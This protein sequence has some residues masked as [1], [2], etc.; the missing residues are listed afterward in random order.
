MSFLKRQPSKLIR[1]ALSLQAYKIVMKQK[2][3]IKQK[4]QKNSSHRE[5]LIYPQISFFPKLLF[6][7]DV[8]GFHS[9]FLS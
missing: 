3:R 7:K 2:N 9:S 5:R 1:S 6:K 8:A 4:N